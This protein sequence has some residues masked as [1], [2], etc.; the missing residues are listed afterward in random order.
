MLNYGKI[1]STIKS[2]LRKD[3]ED[4]NQKIKKMERNKTWRIKWKKSKI[5]FNY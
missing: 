2:N 5:S 4:K 1:R 3:K